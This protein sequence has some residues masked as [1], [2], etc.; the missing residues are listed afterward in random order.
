LYATR[1]CLPEIIKNKGSVVGISSVAGFRGLPGRT[2]YSASKFALN[3]FLEVLRNELLKT[4]VHVLTACPGFTTSNIRK[5]A[6]TKDGSA[7]GESPRREEKMMT[8][9]E[10]AHYIYRAVVKKKRTLVLTSQGKV[11]VWLNKW[12]PAMADR[13]VY[14]VMSKE[15]NA[16]LQ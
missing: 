9:E 10:C 16:P 6:L 2:G 15:A 11:A 5:R 12:W 13:L 14:F 3:G 8:S 7:Q 1:Y 4:G